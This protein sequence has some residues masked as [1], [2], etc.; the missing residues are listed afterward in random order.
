MI[1]TTTTKSLP[2]SALEITLEKLDQSSYEFF[3]TGSRELN[4]KAVNN[5]SD[6][7]FYV[8]D[9]PDVREA[10]NFLGFVQVGD[11]KEM[12]YL[13]FR[14][15][16]EIG[17]K[18]MADMPNSCVLFKH[19]TSGKPLPIHVQAVNDAEWK[20]KAQEFYKQNVDMNW[21]YS[22][23]KETRRQIEKHLWKMA[24]MATKP[25][26]TP[27]INDLNKF[28]VGDK[29]R[30]ICSFKRGATGIVTEIR[31]NPEDNVPIVVNM[32]EKNSWCFATNELEKIQEPTNEAKFRVGDRVKAKI[33][34]YPECEGTIHRIEE[35]KK[36]LYHVRT[37][38]KGFRGPFAASEMTLMRAA[39]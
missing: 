31:R 18:G 25:E 8:Q 17:Y 30:S 34:N 29:V 15:A 35:G 28:K 32:S 38:H 14:N 13:G 5:K 16:E 24:F 19:M 6:W 11:E 20:T 37:D 36:Y 21:L 22:V 27:V 2:K 10:L 26:T 4:P 23:Q 3:L 1:R 33:F 12:N 39:Q 9:G 7:D